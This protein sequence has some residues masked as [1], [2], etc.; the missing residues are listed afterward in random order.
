[1]I[2]F[3]KVNKQFLTP[4]ETVMTGSLRQMWDRQTRGAALLIL[5]AI[6]AV[7]GTLPPTARAV[8][9][10]ASF[11]DRRAVYNSNTSSAAAADFSVLTQAKNTE[12]K[13]EQAIST[14]WKRNSS[15]GA[16]VH[17]HGALI[18]FVMHDPEVHA[19]NGEL[20]LEP[21]PR[22]KPTEPHAAPVVDR[23]AES[24][25]ASRSNV[26]ALSHTFVRALLAATQVGPADDRARSA[27]QTHE[28]D[29]NGEYVATIIDTR[30]MTNPH[31]GVRQDTNALCAAAAGHS[32]RRLNMETVARPAAVSRSLQPVRR[33][34][35]SVPAQKRR[36]S[37]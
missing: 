37:S 30:E 5:L 10:I 28:G 2:I 7:T 4:Q 22:F 33:R 29:P 8:S 13:E 12:P 25:G 14:K 1:L 15:D 32:I 21:A 26:S 31:R 11:R 34:I 16:R 19:A 18:A 9:P 35:E 23:Q 6:A 17:A 36:R 3:N 20:A 27:W 24:T